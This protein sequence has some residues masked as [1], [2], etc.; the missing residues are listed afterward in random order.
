MEDLNWY[1]LTVIQWL[2][3]S[4]LT[5]TAAAWC[6]PGV[7]HRPGSVASVAPWSQAGATPW[8]RPALRSGQLWWVVETPRP[9]PEE[10]LLLS[11]KD[12]RVSS[13][14][15]SKTIDIFDAF[16]LGEWLQD[17]GTALI[18]GFPLGMHLQGCSH[19]V[20]LFPSP[21]SSSS[22]HSYSSYS[23][24]LTFRSKIGLNTSI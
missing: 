24:K 4:W 15:L 23:E 11:Q 8:H 22:S 14:N 2:G 12:L 13:K 21:S 7:P 19:K 9:A 1:F 20:S 6:W 10:N 5:H 17:Q 16:L 18:N 3:L